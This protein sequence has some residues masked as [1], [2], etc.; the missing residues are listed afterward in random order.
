MAIS[1]SFHVPT[2]LINSQATAN[3]GFRNAV[4]AA[5]GKILWQ[6]A[7]PDNAA[8]LWLGQRGERRD[9][10]RFF[11]RQDVCARC[12]DGRILWHFATKGSVIEG[13]SV[14]NGI[15]NWDPAM[16]ALAARR[17]T[18]FTRLPFCSHPSERRSGICQAT[19]DRSVSR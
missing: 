3:C 17:T 2:K 15:L 4:D 18:Y 7:D 8:E 10:W 13:P 6:T 19:F 12:E 5:T 14:V 16:A 9:V 1:N 11:V